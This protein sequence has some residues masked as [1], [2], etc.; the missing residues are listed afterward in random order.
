MSGCSAS[1]CIHYQVSLDRH[2]DEQT[3]KKSERIGRRVRNKENKNIERHKRT[4]KER[5]E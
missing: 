1:A 4:N 2:T 5:N 3:E